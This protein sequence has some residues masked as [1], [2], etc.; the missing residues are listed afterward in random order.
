MRPRYYTRNSLRRRTDV[1]PPLF[2]FIERQSKYGDCIWPPMC[3][4]AFQFS[5]YPIFTGA[6]GKAEGVFEESGGI[7][8]AENT[9]LCDAKLEPQFSRLLDMDDA[10]YDDV[11]PAPR[12]VAVET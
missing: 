2:G 6:P 11:G 4:R 3:K 12:E 7:F 5:A 10:L 8:D 9:R 1:E